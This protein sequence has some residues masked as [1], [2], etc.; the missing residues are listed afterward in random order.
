MD[1]SSLADC[2]ATVVREELLGFAQLNRIPHFVP[3]PLWHI[4]EEWTNVVSVLMDGC[5]VTPPVVLYSSGHSSPKLARTSLA[6]N[7]FITKSSQLT[8]SFYYFT[9][10]LGNDWYE[11]VC[12]VREEIH[13]HISIVCLSI[14]NVSTL[15]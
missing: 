12:T 11:K 13:C 3:T 10:S 9:L 7:L 8:F 15:G 1:V 5:C 4:V 14:R 2:C 6:G